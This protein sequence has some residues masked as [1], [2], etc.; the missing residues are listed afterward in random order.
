LITKKN[1]PLKIRVTRGGNPPWKLRGEGVVSL[2]AI[3]QNKVVPS[4][5]CLERFLGDA[6][7]FRNALQGGSAERNC[8]DAFRI[9]SSERLFRE[10]PQI[11]SWESLS[12]VS[13]NKG[14]LGSLLG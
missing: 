14:S 6:R 1:G 8:R 5:G 4:A 12:K 9:A 2:L 7:S 10:A 3:E 13:L 11:D